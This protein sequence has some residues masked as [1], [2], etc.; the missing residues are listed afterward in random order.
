MTICFHVVSK[1]TGIMR[2]IVT[3][4]YWSELLI[5]KQKGDNKGKVFHILPCKHR[6]E[7]TVLMRGH[8]LMI[9]VEK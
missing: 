4:S 2:D 8:N 1:C 9:F 5:R 7:E 3:L 6:S